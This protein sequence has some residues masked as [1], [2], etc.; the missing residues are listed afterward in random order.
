MGIPL[1]ALVNKVL[2][3]GNGTMFL[4]EILGHLPNFWQG[5]HVAEHDTQLDFL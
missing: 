3:I 4:R 5:P 2:S 1:V